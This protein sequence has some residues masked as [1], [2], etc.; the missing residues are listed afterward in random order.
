MGLA[1]PNL[2]T[3]GGAAEL[4]RPLRDSLYRLYVSSL[5]ISRQAIRAFFFARTTCHRKLRVSCTKYELLFLM[6]S[7][8]AMPKW[9][10]LG[11]KPART[12]S[13]SEPARRAASSAN[14]RGSG[15]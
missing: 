2:I 11:L 4:L 1:R 15:G 8:A 7:H 13:S 12:T 10:H 5:D 6:R 14:R 3:A 9:Q